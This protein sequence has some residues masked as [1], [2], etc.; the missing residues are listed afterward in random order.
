MA[1][2]H[3]RIREYWDRDA[4][5]YDRAASHGVTDPVEAAAWKAALRRALPEPPARVL[6]VGAGT[7]SLSLL[8]AELGYHVTG[9]DLSEGMLEKARTKAAE[10]RLDVTFVQGPADRPPEG[11]FDAVIERHVIWTILDPVAAL[12]AWRSVVVPKG[13]L[14]LLEGV[15]HR[16]DVR[17]RLRE[18]ATRSLR[19]LLRDPA[20]EHHAPYP[21]EVLAVL[22]LRGLPSPDPLLRAVSEAGWTGVRITR[23]R[24]VEWAQRLREHPVIGWLEQRPHYVVVADA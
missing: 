13:R 1:D 14:V 15:W 8:A 3:D 21:A 4:R 10:R 20:H 23:L 12:A 6:D 9:L 22:P 11:P 24:D 18:H 16:G 5:T 2:L 7:G 17:E 19:A